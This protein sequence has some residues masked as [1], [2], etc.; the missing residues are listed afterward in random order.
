MRA[1]ACIP[2]ATAHPAGR[3]LLTTA[4]GRCGILLRLLLSRPGLF[5]NYPPASAGRHPTAACTAAA[6]CFPISPMSAPG[7][8]R[9]NSSPAAA[10]RAALVGW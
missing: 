4:L 7:L 2:L 8:H 1:T 6:G 5:T 10:L 9:T 3:R